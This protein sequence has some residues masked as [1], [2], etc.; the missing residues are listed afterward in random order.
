MIKSTIKKEKASATLTIV[1]DEKF[2]APFKQ[3][4]LKKLKKN[5][6][7]DGFRPGNVPDAIAVRE[8]GDNVV[9]AEVA[10]EVMER[11]L[12][13]Q[14]RENKLSILGNPSVELKKF[15]PYSEIEFIAK[16]PIMPEIKFDYSKVKVK[17]PET[18]IDEKRI[19]EAVEVL[20][21]QM[22]KKSP[23]DKAIKNG[24][25]I[26][27]DFEGKREGK[28]LEGAAA[29]NHTM[30]VGDKTF[31]PGF[32]ENL[33]GLKKGDEKT[34]KVT[35]PKD[36][37]AKDL[38]S[39]KVEF[40]VKIK[41]VYNV[42]LPEVNDEF[43]K[44]M[45][46]KSN[47][48]E[49]RKDIAKV[50]E[51]R[52]QEE[53]DKAYNNQVI[54]EVIKNAKFDIPEQLIKD[55]TNQLES[56]MIKNLHNSGLDKEKYLKMYNKSEADLEKEIGTEAEKRVKAAL[57]MKDLISKYTLQV[58]E[59]E[60]DQEI[61]KMAEQYKSDPKIQEELTHGHFRDDLRNHLL[62]QKAVSKLAEITS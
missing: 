44:N 40:S 3:A 41:D 6:K 36:Y 25:E 15:V 26:V 12:D 11:A 48:E 33:V 7:V 5:L 62:T 32:E 13:N 43:A 8:L 22:A 27:F 21:K 20:R 61:A 9:Q 2:I 35:F 37:H 49:M 16:F 39:A 38:Q 23:T 55:Q 51:E 17:K 54:D 10:Q 56:E 57:I 52:E 46:A 59:L 4:V 1:A 14:L 31:I 53:A 34:F 58:S 30:V 60:L 24:N 19:D 18:K 47:V 50:L 29:T 28:P 42:E 45:S